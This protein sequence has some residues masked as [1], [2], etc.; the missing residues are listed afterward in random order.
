MFRMYNSC[1][2]FDVVYLFKQN[3]AYWVRI[4]DWSSD[5]CSSDLVEQLDHGLEV[6]HRLRGVVEHDVELVA[7]GA[8]RLRERPGLAPIGVDA[9]APFGQ[10]GDV[11]VDDCDLVPAPG[12]LEDEVQPDVAV[13]SCD[14][15][16]QRPSAS[17]RAARYT[18]SDR[19]STRLNSSH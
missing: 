13:D 19:K 6:G 3:T 7:V 2:C 16:S 5:V 8:Q 12:Q 17:V 11:A 10:V 18:A 15:R 1:G 9:P 4:S 14:Q